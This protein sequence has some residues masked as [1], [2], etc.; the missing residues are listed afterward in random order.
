VGN[1]YKNITTIGPPQTEVAEALMRHG[2]QAYVTPTRERD[3]V[4]FDRES[5]EAT[6][7]GGLGDLALTLSQ[8]LG[9][10]TLAAVVYEDDVPLLALYDSGTQ[11]GKYN[12]TGPST[13]PDGGLARRFGASVR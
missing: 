2:R 5:D 7:P 4:V 8:E 1:W 10:P 12:S 6:D 11:V 9:C 3:T 13:L